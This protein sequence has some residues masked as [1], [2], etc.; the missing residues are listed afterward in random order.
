MGME[1][2]KPQLFSASLC[3]VGMPLESGTTPGS[4]YLNPKR[5]TGGNLHRSFRKLR[6]QGTSGTTCPRNRLFGHVSGVPLSVGDLAIMR[7]L[8]PHERS[9]KPRAAM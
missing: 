1:I 8:T 4:T 5:L 9:Q 7:S 3:M 2:M 6:F